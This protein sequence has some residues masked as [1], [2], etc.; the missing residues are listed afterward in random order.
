MVDRPD[1][2]AELDLLRSQRGRLAARLAAP[3][4]Y[5]AVTVFAWAVAFAIPIGSHYLTGAGAWCALL[6]IV[7]FLL[8]Q[9]ALARASGIDLGLRTWQYP[10][11]RIS[12]IAMIAIIVAGF[13]GEAALLDHG[14]TAVAVLVGV[15]ATLASAGCWQAHLRAVRRDI[16]TGRGAR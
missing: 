11:G 4:W 8:A 2:I 9:R 10:S 12:T 16:R 14:L 13:E 1:E 5:V 3:R 6:A 7:V 15:L